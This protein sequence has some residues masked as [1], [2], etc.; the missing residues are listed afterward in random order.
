MAVVSEARLPRVLL[1]SSPRRT[2]DSRGLLSTGIESGVERV[3]YRPSFDAEWPM[4]NAEDLSRGR[5]GA[6]EYI[7]PR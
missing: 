5:I 3:M 1:P 4:K 2:R 6:G 7:I